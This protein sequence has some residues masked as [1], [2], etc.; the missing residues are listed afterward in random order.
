VW[1]VYI[2]ERGIL[3]SQKSEAHQSLNWITY[4]RGNTADN[5]YPQPNAN[6]KT[7]LR[8]LPKSL[9]NSTITD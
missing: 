6:A 8:S 9:V 5:R 7:G 3:Q 2:E 4:S 1:W